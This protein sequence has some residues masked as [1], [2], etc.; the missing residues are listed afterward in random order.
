VKNP[1]YSINNWTKARHSPYKKS[2]VL[3]ESSKQP[4]KAESSKQLSKAESSKQLSK[5]ESS[6]QLS[7]AESSKQLSKAES[8]KQLSKAESSKQLSKAERTIVRVPRIYKHV[9]IYPSDETYVTNFI[10]YNYAIISQDENYFGAVCQ[11]SNRVH[12]IK[13]K[14]TNGLILAD[15]M[16][17]KKLCDP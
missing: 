15:C 2:S 11:S 7:K 1:N 6:K 3:S 17:T 10:T 4:S 14:K 13:I 12:F 5:A 9:Y 8:S 16:K